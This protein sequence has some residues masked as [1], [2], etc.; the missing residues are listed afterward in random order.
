[1]SDD[2]PMEVERGRGTLH[3]TPER[4]F[5]LQEI[6]KDVWKWEYA[7]GPQTQ[8][9]TFPATTRAKATR[10]VHQK[11]NRDLRIQYLAQRDRGV[12]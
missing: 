6:E 7:I 3:A 8:S 9:G 4:R 10:R 12:T 5:F 11:M 2:F 1:M